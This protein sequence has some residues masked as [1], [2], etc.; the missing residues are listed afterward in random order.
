MTAHTRSVAE[1]FSSHRFADAYNHLAPDVEWIAVGEGATIGK[2][3]VIAACEAAL[4]AM[5]EVDTVLTRFV[6][7]ADDDASAI[8]VIAR[9][10]DQ[11]GTTSVVSSCDVYEFRD[12]HV[13]RITSYAVELPPAESPR[14]R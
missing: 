11:H 5:A 2:S 8:D 6:V 9:Y 10:T 12:A 4:V 1:A 14:T 13:V 3:A 7:A